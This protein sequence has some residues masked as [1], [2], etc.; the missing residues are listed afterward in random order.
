MY[1]KFSILNLYFL[2]FNFL[3][4]FFIDSDQE[5]IFEKVGS[6]V[7]DNAFGGYNACIFAY[8]Q[9]GMF[10]IFITKNTFIYTN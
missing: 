4:L 1:F 10:I 5:D 7:L 8:G 6:S 9:T 3:K 2:L